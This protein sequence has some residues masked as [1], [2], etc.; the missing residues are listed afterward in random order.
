[1]ARKFLKHNVSQPH[2]MLHETWW[3]WIHVKSGF[4]GENWY[5]LYLAIETTVRNYKCQLC[6][7]ATTTK[8]HLT[9][10]IARHQTCDI[11]DM[12][13]GG[14]RAKRLLKSH[15]LKNHE[16]SSGQTQTYYECGKCKKR[17]MYQCRLNDHMKTKKCSPT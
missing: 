12:S 13:F 14:K 11:C 9:V 16:N 8:S 1:M 6:D 10:H 7:F 4:N 3:I 17:F 5:A 15:M 2:F